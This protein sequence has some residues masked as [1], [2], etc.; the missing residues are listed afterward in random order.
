MIV[1]LGGRSRRMTQ[2]L[3]N[4]QSV[5]LCLCHVGCSKVPG[6]VKLEPVIV[7]MTKVMLG[8]I[9]P[10][11]EPPVSELTPNGVTQTQ[12]NVPRPC[13]VQRHHAARVSLGDLCREINLTGI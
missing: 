1:F 7:T 6:G 10:V 12:C 3:G 4:S 5:H 11:V 2:L 9:P 13:G 8:I